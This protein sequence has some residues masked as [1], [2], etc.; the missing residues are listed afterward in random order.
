MKRAYLPVLFIP[1][2]A[3][4][5]LLG[6]DMEKVAILAVR[7]I[8]QHRRGIEVAHQQIRYRKHHLAFSSRIGRY[9]DL[10]LELDIGDPRLSSRLILEDD[11][12]RARGGA[13]KAGRRSMR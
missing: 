13:G 2:H 5:A 8:L 7:A 4:A 11:L 6:A 12:Q 1:S 9:G 3:V 10:V